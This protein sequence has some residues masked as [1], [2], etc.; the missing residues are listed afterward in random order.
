MPDGRRLGPNW[1]EETCTTRLAD[2]F[3]ERGLT[4]AQVIGATGIGDR[5]ITRMTTLP[6]YRLKPRQRAIFSELLGVDP[7]DLWVEPPVDARTTARM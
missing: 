7:D 2:L 6:H 3:R 1:P 4:R 5:T